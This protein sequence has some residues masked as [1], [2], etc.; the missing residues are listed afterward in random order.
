NHYGP[1]YTYAT[2]KAGYTCAVEPTVINQSACIEEESI[3]GLSSHP[4][5]LI[6]RFNLDDCFTE[7]ADGLLCGAIPVFGSL[8]RRK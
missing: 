8:Q 4:Q 3:Y 2:S 7:F 6:A 5:R 1:A